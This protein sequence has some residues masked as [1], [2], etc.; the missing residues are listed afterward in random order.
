MGLVLADCKEGDVI[1]VFP[2]SGMLYVLR[3]NVAGAGKSSTFL[4]LV[5][6]ICK[7]S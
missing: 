2:V 7:R 5:I 6:A 4:L 3:L 1:C